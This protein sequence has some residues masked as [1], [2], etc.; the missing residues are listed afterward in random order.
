MLH[1]CSLEPEL[2]VLGFEAA[3]IT[4]NPECIRIKIN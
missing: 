4:Y 2:E 3:A 1:R